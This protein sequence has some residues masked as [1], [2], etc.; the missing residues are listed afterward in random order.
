[1]RLKKSILMK[2]YIFI[3]FFLVCGIAFSQGQRQDPLY[4]VIQDVSKDYK[5]F[6][7]GGKN[8]SI[9]NDTRIVNQ[10][11]KPL[12]VETLRP[13]LNVAI[14]IIRDSREN[15]VKKIVVMDSKPV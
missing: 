10:K 11:G 6:T 3:M 15:T 14:E 4:G 12:R 1:M 13:N 2:A 9:S 7:M 5:S 8:Y